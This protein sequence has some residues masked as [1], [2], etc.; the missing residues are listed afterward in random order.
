[1]LPY[2]DV[3]GE[4]ISVVSDIACVQQLSVVC[5]SVVCDSLCFFFLLITGKTSYSDKQGK[6]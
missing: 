3:E 2:S 4:G 1:M 5:D 6:N